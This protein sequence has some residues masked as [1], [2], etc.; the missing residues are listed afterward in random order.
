MEAEAGASLAQEEAKQSLVVRS[1]EEA[2]MDDFELGVGVEEALHERET[3]GKE[4]PT[5]RG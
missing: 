1:E 5:L 3:P 2:G 4:P